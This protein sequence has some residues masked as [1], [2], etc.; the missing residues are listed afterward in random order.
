MSRLANAAGFSGI[1]DMAIMS[2]FAP[3]LETVW[4]GGV[5]V[6]A[7]ELRVRLS[8]SGSNLTVRK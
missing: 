8:I 6:R 5:M 3:V 2:T 1:A 4:L 7:S